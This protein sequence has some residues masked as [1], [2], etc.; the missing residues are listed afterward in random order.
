MYFGGGDP[1]LMHNL[2]QTHKPIK[3][4][5]EIE[6]PAGNL[7]QSPC[8]HALEP[9]ITPSVGGRD[10]V[11]L[12]PYAAF[13]RQVF[14]FN[15]QSTGSKRNFCKRLSWDSGVTCAPWCLF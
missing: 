12:E 8:L 9:L 1:I 3:I 14:S 7:L 15:L 10:S 4:S 2:L 13:S 5:D 11:N 6:S